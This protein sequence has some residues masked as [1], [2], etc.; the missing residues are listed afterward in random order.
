MTES[1]GTDSIFLRSLDAQSQFRSQMKLLGKGQR[2]RPS[3]FLS[4]SSLPKRGSGTSLHSQGGMD[5]P[6]MA[7]MD[8]N[9]SFGSI[10][11]KV[12]GTFKTENPVSVVLIAMF[13]CE[14]LALIFC[15]ALA[16]AS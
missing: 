7:G 11:D 12:N 1:Y 15:F 14:A 10:R 2:P 5:S 13:Y 16:C 3:S 4:S 8:R 6:L 9:T